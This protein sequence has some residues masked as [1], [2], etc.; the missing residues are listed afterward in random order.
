MNI[1]S[2]SLL[3]T[4]IALVFN[5]VTNTIQA[6][7]VLKKGGRLAIAGDS[8]TQQKLYSNYLETYFLVCA[9]E[10][11]IKVIQLG[12]GGERAPG[13]ANRM[14][15]DLMPWN[16]TVVTTCYGMNDGGYTKY[17]EQ[18]GQSYEKAMR[19]IIT[20]VLNSGAAMIIGSPGVVDSQTWKRDQAD[21]DTI[22]NDN[23]NQLREI[24]RRLAG[25]Y[26]CPFADVYGAMM[27]AMTN[28]KAVLGLEYHVAGRDGI[29]P[30]ENGH[31]VMAHAFLRA[32]GMDGNIGTITVDFPAKASATEGHSI[33]NCATGIVEA[34]SSRYPFCFTGGS[35]DPNGTISILNFVP[36]QQDLNRFILV[37]RKLPTAQA[38]IQ[39]DQNTKKFSR[40]QLEQGINLAAEFPDNPFSKPFSNII[41]AVGQKQA[42]ETTMVQ[43]I[44]AGFRH[45]DSYFKDDSIYAKAKETLQQRLMA[46]QEENSTSLKNMVKPVR[47]RIEIRPCQDQ[48]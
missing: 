8:I 44:F 29:H 19:M 21:H 2:K 16:P 10:L 3:M 28:S 18:I 32:L 9:P 22:Y 15:G 4:V 6:E 47:H 40:A 36:F 46:K 17:S 35:N 37:V 13:F 42:Y 14:K 34:L 12:C 48:P 43:E 30:G 1:F 31:L 24:D 11:D 7:P 33:V 20:N 26:Q 41:A 38:E 45:L 5:Y 25:E 39:W 27:S 23:L